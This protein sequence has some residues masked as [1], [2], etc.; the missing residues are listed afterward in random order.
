MAMPLPATLLRALSG[1]APIA[2]DT[3]LR[4]R[5][6]ASLVAGADRVLDVG[7]T[8]GRLASFLP[9]TVV[10]AANVTAPADVLLTGAELP[11][12]SGSFDAAVSIDVVEHLPPADRAGHARELRR[13]ARGMV[14]LCCP[15]GSPGHR[16]SEARLADWH[17]RTTGRP[18]AYL[19]QHLE[20]GLPSLV[21]VRALGAELGPHAVLFQGDYREAD[22][23]FRL[24]TLVRR[25][26]WRGPELLWALARA[27]DG[28]E[29]RPEPGEFANRV[30][31]VS[32]PPPSS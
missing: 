6:V 21:E 30:F 7:G 13:V 8:P 25:R 23:L 9:G 15:L 17:R 14:V 5:R 31:V 27:R 24:G 18:H 20:H 16:E 10:I 28:G 4:H 26:P 32:P 11:F 22:R 12:D 3:A 2:A 1:R 19:E 29:L